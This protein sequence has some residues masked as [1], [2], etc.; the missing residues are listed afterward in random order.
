MVDKALTLL[1]RMINQEQP[2]SGFIDTISPRLLTMR[3]N[4]EDEDS[5]VFTDGNGIITRDD[6]AFKK[7]F[8]EYLLETFKEEHLS[9]CLLRVSDGHMQVMGR[10]ETPEHFLDVIRGG[11][12]IPETTA[13]IKLRD[14][15]CKLNYF[16]YIQETFKERIIKICLNQD[17]PQKFAQIYF[18]SEDRVIASCNAY[19]KD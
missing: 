9:S 4:N 10:K 13:E 19:R 12:K 11:L 15:K 5:L 8:G 6:P 7:Y 1:K 16:D 3:L 18:I 17:E 2:E 14:Y